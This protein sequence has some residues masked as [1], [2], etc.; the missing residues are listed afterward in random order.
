M[1]NKFDGKG[2]R[3]WPVRSYQFFKR[4][5]LL[6]WRGIKKKV[7]SSIYIYH[8]RFSEIASRRENLRKGTGAIK[9]ASWA[10]YLTAYYKYPSSCCFNAPGIGSN[11]SRN[12]AETIPSR[13]W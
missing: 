8:F 13:Q 5:S 9:L 6:R 11:Y 12:I 7:K 2:M 3:R 4:D 10:R 1:I